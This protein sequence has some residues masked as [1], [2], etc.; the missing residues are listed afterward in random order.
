MAFMPP[1][2]KG[3]SSSSEMRLAT[4]LKLMVLNSK[5]T[6]DTTVVMYVHCEKGILCR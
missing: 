6:K 3:S 1:V 5:S 4:A 2:P